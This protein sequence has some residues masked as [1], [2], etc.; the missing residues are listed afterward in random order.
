MRRGAH[1][2]HAGFQGIAA[3]RLG[4]SARTKARSVLTSSPARALGDG[5]TAAGKG[6]S[7]AIRVTKCIRPGFGAV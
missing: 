7:V 2:G 1:G 6:Q 5:L 3:L 4:P